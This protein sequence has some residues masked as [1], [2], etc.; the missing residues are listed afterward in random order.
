MNVKNL[1]HNTLSAKFAQLLVA[2]ADAH[3]DNY[4]WQQSLADLETTLVAKKEA[5]AKGEETAYINHSKESYHRMSLHATSEKV[6]AEHGEP[7]LALPVYLALS[8]TWNDVLAWA[9]SE[10]DMKSTL[11]AWRA[12]WERKTEELYEKY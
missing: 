3:E 2:T 8:Y 5:A 11:P 6:C 12:E 9:E 4:D 1:P 10:F 7:A